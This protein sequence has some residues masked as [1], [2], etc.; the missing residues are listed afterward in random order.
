MLRPH[1]LR[2]S[3]LAGA[4]ALLACDDGTGPDSD[5]TGPDSDPIT[6][7]S[8]APDSSHLMVSGALQLT[9]TVLRADGETVDS[10]PVWS[11]EP[12]GVVQ[13]DGSGRVLA[14]AP[15]R[16]EVA[17]TIGDVTGA[18]VVHVEAPPTVSVSPQEPVI[19]SGA[20]VQMEMVGFS[21]P[22]RWASS[23]EQVATVGGSGLA[24]GVAAGATTLT[25]RAVDAP[26]ITASTRLTVVLP[27]GGGP[28]IAAVRGPGGETV[29][30]Q[31]LSGEITVTVNADLSPTCSTAAEI[32]LLVDSTVAARQAYTGGPLQWSPTID[33]RQYANGEHRLGAEI[34]AADGGV[35]ESASQITV[36]FEN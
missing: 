17:A 1:P 6:A 23:N 5:G 3:L 35:V 18:A 28:T 4:A 24:T 36:R 2:L 33:T 20:Q 27:A 21:G 15:G 7:V 31:D 13:V 16:A 11:A 25:A 34:R 10:A 14:V 26:A 22:V 30:L 19:C 9:A 32:V 8:V 29:D 12:A